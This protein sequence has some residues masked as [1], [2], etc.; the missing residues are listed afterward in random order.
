VAS[1][2]E[3]IRDLALQIGEYQKESERRKGSY[4]ELRRSVAVV[5]Q[6]RDRLLEVVDALS[7]NTCDM[8]IKINI[9]QRFIEGMHRH[10]VAKEQEWQASLQESSKAGNGDGDGDGVGAE[11]GWG[12]AN[13][14]SVD[15][16]LSST[17]VGLATNE[18]HEGSIRFVDEEG[19]EHAAVGDTAIK[20]NAVDEDTREQGIETLALKRVPN[21]PT[22]EIL[23]TSEPEASVEAKSISEGI[24]DAQSIEIVDLDDPD[25]DTINPYCP[26][27]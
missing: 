23:Q 10:F 9:L 6:D 27:Q 14:S 5:L 13:I 22:P 19:R 4:D 24:A 18:K 3:I 7:A 2:E 12:D 20:A 16:S 8:A 1:K 25:P 26:Q 11:K 15:T 17:R 21:L